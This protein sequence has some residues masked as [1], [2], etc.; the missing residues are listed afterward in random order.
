MATAQQDTEITL[1]T[2]RMLAIFFGFVVVCAFF[3]GIGFSLGRKTT[4]SA[5]TVWPS[6]ASAT[7]ATVVRPSA[8]KNNSPQPTPQSSSGDFG[9]Y[10]AVGEKNADTVLTPADTTTQNPKGQA[11]ASAA[12][13]AE[14]APEAAS[15]SGG[16]SQRRCGGA[17]RGAQEKTVSRLYG[18]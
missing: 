4:L 9:F 13:P 18:K 2:G 12:S 17:R 8:V 7:P 14:A 15:G 10:K 3:F 11:P 6:G 5:T 16:K 1:G